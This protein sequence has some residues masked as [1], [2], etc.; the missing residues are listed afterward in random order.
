[1]AIPREV[2]VSPDLRSQPRTATAYEQL[3]SDAVTALTAAARLT[4]TERRP[5]GT[6][7]SRPCDWAEFVTLALVLQP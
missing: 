1:M 3:L 4:C 6:A 5:D 7:A 2:I